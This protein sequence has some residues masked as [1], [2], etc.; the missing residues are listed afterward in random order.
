MKPKTLGIDIG[1]VIIQ[2]AETAG[3]TSFFSS[4]Y[5][6][7]PP[8]ADA[9]EAIAQLREERF[10]DR[11]CLVSKCGPGVQQKPLNWLENRNFY[12]LTGIAPDRVHFCRERADKAPICRRLGVDIFIDDRIDVLRHLETVETLIQFQSTEKAK[13][14]QADFELIRVN[15]WMNVLDQLLG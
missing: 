3:D 13:K 4:A 8:V 14:E 1:G 9:I 12:V 2:P 5:L 7:T 15:S 10:G 11:I 6:D